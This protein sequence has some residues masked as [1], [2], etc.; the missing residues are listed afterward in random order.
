VSF[1]FDLHSAAMFD[2]HMHAVPVPCHDY[3]VLKATSQGHSMAHHG[4]GKACVNY[5]PPSRDG[6]CATS[7]HSDSSGYHAEFHKVC[8]QKHTD[9]LN[10]RASSSYISDYHVDFHEDHGTVGEWQ[11][12]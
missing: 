8:Y 5:H 3:A 2:S 9:P 7:L 11:G 6:I 1:P 4:H 10:C 12:W